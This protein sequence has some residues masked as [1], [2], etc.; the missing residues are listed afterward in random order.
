MSNPADAVR[1]EVTYDDGSTAIFTVARASVGGP[2]GDAVARIIAGER[3]RS[4][5]LRPGTIKSVV[6]RP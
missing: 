2:T 5:D 1:F 6:R 3:Q 4:G